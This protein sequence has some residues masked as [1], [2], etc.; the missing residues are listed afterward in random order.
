MNGAGRGST[1]YSVALSESSDGPQT[2]V[3]RAVVGRPAAE[4]EI[5]T[6]GPLD[7]HVGQVAQRALELF[8]SPGCGRLLAMGD[9]HFATRPLRQR[10]DGMAHGRRWAVMLV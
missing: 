5:R 6:A 4:H 2:T 7:H 9:L 1:R 10:V 3:G 8:L